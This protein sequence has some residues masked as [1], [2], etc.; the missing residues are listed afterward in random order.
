MANKWLAPLWVG[1][2]LEHHTSPV[3]PKHP[4]PQ[5]ERTPNDKKKKKKKKKNSLLPYLLGILEKVNQQLQKK[6]S[7]QPHTRVLSDNGK[8]IRSTSSESKQNQRQS[9]GP[10]P[11]SLP[12]GKVH[13]R[14]NPSSQHFQVVGTICSMAFQAH[15]T[16]PQQLSLRCTLIS[17]QTDH[18]KPSEGRDGERQEK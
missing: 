10:F 4:A 8:T 14:P 12:C 6:K 7:G 15:I 5:H 18:N 9:D 13:H 2:K 11:K 1:T 17:L 16:K 3:E